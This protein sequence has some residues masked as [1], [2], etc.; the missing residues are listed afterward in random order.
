MIGRLL[1][2]GIAPLAIGSAIALGV[3]SHYASQEQTGPNKPSL[4]NS[5]KEG[6]LDFAMGDPYADID[7]AGFPITP[8]DAL[9]AVLPF[10][11]TPRGVIDVGRA[12]DAVRFAKDNPEY[13]GLQSMMRNATVYGDRLNNWYMNQAAANVKRGYTTVDYGEG[14]TYPYAPL[15]ER[16][17]AYASSGSISNGLNASGDIVFGAYNMRHS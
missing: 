15:Y 16:Q 7:L 5:V 4:F 14:S 6:L 11:P 13:G 12:V 3:H 10:D 8:A 9:D 2:G 1:K 17:G